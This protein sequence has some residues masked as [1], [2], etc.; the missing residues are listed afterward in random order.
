MNF[1]SVFKI[2]RDIYFIL[3]FIIFVFSPFLETN[4]CQTL[5][6]KIFIFI[7]I[8]LNYLAEITVLQEAL[9]VVHN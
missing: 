3:I 2:N 4:D 7:L 9:A 1:Y 6:M 8:T 5:K